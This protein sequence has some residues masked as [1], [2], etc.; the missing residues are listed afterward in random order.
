[1]EEMAE[2]VSTGKV[3]AMIVSGPPGIG[4]SYGVEQALEK[5]NMFED[6][7]RFAKRA[8]VTRKGKR[9][10]GCRT[11]LHLPSNQ[12]REEMRLKS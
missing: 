7:R 6:M 12:V 9:T 11:K 4:K 3:R 2:A 1:M 8:R 10:R 5:R